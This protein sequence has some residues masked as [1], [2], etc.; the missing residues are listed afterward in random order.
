MPDDVAILRQI[1]QRELETINAYEE[2]L[3]RIKDPALRTIV[4][5]ITDEEREH[6]AE[7][8]ELIV[9]RDARQKSSAQNSRRHVDQALGLVE[10]PAEEAPRAAAA[11]LLP[12][13]AVDLVPPPAP[14]FEAAAWS[15]GTLKRNP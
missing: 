13:G 14:I 5:H 1:L 6:V 12:G 7:M 11:V 9:E 8:Y 3:E 15:V 4:E 2:M 10:P